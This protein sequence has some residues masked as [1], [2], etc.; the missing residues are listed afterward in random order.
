MQELSIKEKEYFQSLSFISVKEPRDRMLVLTLKTI[1]DEGEAKAIA[2][3]MKKNSLLIIDD[4]KG[5]K[6]ARRLGL[7]I[8]GTLDLLKAMKLKGIIR[9]NHS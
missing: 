6:V 4:L 9:K 2:L 7:E 8:I 1:V 5:R 3:S